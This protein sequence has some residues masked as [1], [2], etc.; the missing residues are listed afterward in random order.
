MNYHVGEWISFHA[1]A[2]RV[3]PRLT[4]SITLGELPDGWSR[5][6]GQARTWSGLVG[7]V[8]IAPFTLLLTAT[9][10]HNIGLNAPYSWLSGSTIA[11]LA[12]TVSLFIGIPVA[13]AMNAWRITRLG[14]RRQGGALDGLIALEVAPLHLAVVVIGLLVGGL[15]VA[16]LVAD[17]YACMNGVRSAC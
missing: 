14:L 4:A 11:I 2:E 8:L 16:H 10:L 12:G 13:I 5:K 9:V 3:P 6:G 1:R 15:F 17:S 7:L